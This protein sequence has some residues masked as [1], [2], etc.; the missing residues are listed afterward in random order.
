[1]P[2]SGN[3]KNSSPPQRIVKQFHHAVA[4]KLN[5][6]WISA[7]GSQANYTMR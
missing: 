1:M 7:Y 6:I 3:L 2:Y 5:F 4:A